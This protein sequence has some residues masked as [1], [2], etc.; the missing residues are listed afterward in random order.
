MVWRG[1]PEELLNQPLPARSRAHA[2]PAHTYTRTRSCPQPLFAALGD[3]NDFG[4]EDARSTT[5]LPRAGAEDASDVVDAASS[6]PSPQ[7]KRGKKR[8]PVAS[9]PDRAGEASFARQEEVGAGPLRDSDDGSDGETS[10]PHLQAAE[11]K[12]AAIE[13]RAE[14]MALGQLLLRP[15]QRRDLEDA[16]YN[17]HTFNDHGLPQVA[18]APGARS[19][20]LP[21]TA[22][23]SRF[24]NSGSLTTSASTRGRP[25][26][27]WSCHRKHLAARAT[28]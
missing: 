27:A 23:P 28:Q 9:A 7:P 16:A 21:P 17:R 15:A 13:R 2:C 4:V 3:E 10:D 24:L 25:A 1:T 20:A 12:Q 8:A 19:H 14:A 6:A 11:S 18:P 22:A 5:G 26:M